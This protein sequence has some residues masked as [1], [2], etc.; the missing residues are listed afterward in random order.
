MAEVEEL[1]KK[2][3]L[4]E[5]ASLFSNPSSI[6]SLLNA[7]NRDDCKDT[8]IIISTELSA[9]QHLVVSSSVP[10]G[11]VALTTFVQ[12]WVDTGQALYLVVTRDEQAFWSDPGVVSGSY[13]MK[14]WL[15]CLNR[16]T[17]DVTNLTAGAVKG[18]LHF[19]GFNIRDTL[20]T[21][22]KPTLM[23]LGIILHE[24]GDIG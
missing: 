15:P 19:A 12:V 8:T 2:L 10:T 21:K 14:Y 11:Y 23:G 22:L 4:V 5:K 1:L 20:W 16:W 6:L 3:I 17:F 7:Y 9:G 13:D 18:Y 24:K